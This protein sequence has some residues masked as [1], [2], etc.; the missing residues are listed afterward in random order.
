MT[1]KYRVMYAVR[2]LVFVCRAFPTAYCEQLE[3]NTDNVG[4][5]LRHYLIF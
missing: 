1:V 4:N 5:E 3:N 2:V